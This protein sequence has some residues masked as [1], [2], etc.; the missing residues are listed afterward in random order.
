[1]PV[2]N[3]PQ[4]PAG[5]WNYNP[6]TNTWSY[7]LNGS[8]VTGW[9]K[10]YSATSGKDEWYYFDTAGSMQTGWIAESGAVYYLQ[11]EANGNQG[12]AFTNWHDIR[13]VYYYFNPSSC[14]L[15]QMRSAAEAAAMGIVTQETIEAAMAAQQHALMQQQQ[16]AMLAQQQEALLA[17]QQALQLQQQQ[18]L[19]QQQ[20][21]L[22]N[23]N[24]LTGLNGLN[25]L[26][27]LDANT[28]TALA[29]AGYDQNAIAAMLTGG[30][31]L[32]LA[33]LNGL[34]PANLNGAAGLNMLGLD[35]L[36]LSNLGLSYVTQSP[37]PLQSIITGDWNYDA[38]KNNWTFKQNGVTPIAGGF[39]TI[40]DK[41]GASAH[42][43][44]FDETGV[45][46]TGIR[47]I[48]S[49]VYYFSEADENLGQAQSG[50]MTIF[51]VL[52]H[53]NE[54]TYELDML[55]SAEVLQSITYTA[56]AVERARYTG[57]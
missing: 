3:Q 57:Q 35:G 7:N 33:G 51:N 48:G 9:N 20:A 53:F 23:L 49:K 17:Q 4:A 1:M 36:T 40:A 22:P 34:D 38:S 54:N 43:Y 45:M 27:G 47:V 18:A 15:E 19:L 46:Y 21:G 41:T 8:N 42:K 11:P 39:A 6:L 25:G 24:G 26:G 29:M 2:G 14:A 32:G 55:N 52:C 56:Y 31:G 10:I 44:Y 5:T 16:Q 37:Q 50:W 30:A 13:G 28:L 12:R